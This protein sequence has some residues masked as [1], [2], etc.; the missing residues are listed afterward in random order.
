MME[1]FPIKEILL[2]WSAGLY[3]G[4]GAA[5]KSAYLATVVVPRCRIFIATFVCEDGNFVVQL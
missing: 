4:A 3:L 2:Q 5:L 1:F